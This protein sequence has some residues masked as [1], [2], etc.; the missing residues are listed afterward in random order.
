[1]K[2]ISILL[3]DDHAIVRMGLASLFATTDD[4]AVAGSV[5]DGPSALREAD[6]LHPDVILLDFLM[7]GMNGL[8]VTNAL[9][10]DDP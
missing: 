7:P 3:V 5:G 10:A 4:L 9:L 6:R 2:K 8:E 1:M